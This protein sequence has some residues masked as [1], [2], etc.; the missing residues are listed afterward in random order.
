VKILQWFVRNRDALDKLRGL[1]ALIECAPEI[2]EAN[3]A[4]MLRQLDRAVG[5]LEDRDEN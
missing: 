2:R 4:L 1:R 5:E 3:R